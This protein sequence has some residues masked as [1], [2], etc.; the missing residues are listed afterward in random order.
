MIP[1][2]RQQS[3]AVEFWV[4]PDDGK[5]VFLFA[6]NLGASDEDAYVI[7]EITSGG[8]RLFGIEVDS[9]LEIPVSNDG[10]IVILPNRV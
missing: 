2:T 3:D 10:T 8:I 4:G 5:G 6:K 9:D 1:V 7:A